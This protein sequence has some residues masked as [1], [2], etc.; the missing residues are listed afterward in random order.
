M[1]NAK[2]V[3]AMVI[4]LA[5]AISMAIPASAATITIN[6]PVDHVEDGVVYSA[7]KMATLSYSQANNA[8]RYIAEAAWVPFFT[9]AG[10]TYFNYDA[11]NGVVTAK[12]SV[13]PV[14]VAAA[15]LAFA[16]ANKATVGDPQTATSAAGTATITGTEKGYYLFSS[17]L[18]TLLML[19]TAG[20]GDDVE[21][22]MTITEKNK[23]PTIDKAIVENG[24]P[25]DVND[26]AINDVVSYKIEVVKQAGA[27]NYTVVDTLSKGLT[28]NNDAKISL[29]GAAATDITP[30]ISEDNGSTILT[31]DI[32]GEETLADGQIITITYTATVDTDAVNDG[33]NENKALLKYGND[34]DHLFSTEESEVNTYVWAFDILKHNSANQVLAN[35]EFELYTGYNTQTKEYTGKIEFVK[36]IVDGSEDGTY[37]V[38]TAQET[39][40][41][42]V[43]DANGAIV[44]KGLD[45]GTYYL[46]ETVAPE[47]YNILT[48]PVEVV[49]ASNTTDDV[50]LTKTVNG[51]ED[52][53]TVRVLNNTGAELPSTGGTGTVIF[54][55][56]GSILVLA[57]GVLLVVR[58]RMSKVV[59]AR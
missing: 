5:L 44:L 7:W 38:K 57:M 49:I 48:T 52:D 40:V 37:R 29:N 41:T 42:L 9:G 59:Y 56:V 27:K 14:A 54:V 20:D 43:S 15:A 8:Y 28:F 32:D 36:N 1:K 16:E 21:G 6:Q 13:D 46:K 31:F 51:S 4:V 30:A 26:A 22:N 39:A 53:A 19:D 50:T 24:T 25:V 47:G 45:Q 58:K 3:L 10:S 55:T 35:A 11:D 18:G 34:P 17:T 33:A 2:K 12:D 23:V